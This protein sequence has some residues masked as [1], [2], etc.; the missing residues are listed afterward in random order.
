MDQARTASSAVVYAIS[1]KI[2]GL[3]GLLG[4]IP[5]TPSP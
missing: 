2:N 1:D 5:Q 3:F 4:G